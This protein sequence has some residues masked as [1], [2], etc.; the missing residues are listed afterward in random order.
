MTVTFCINAI[1]H[2]APLIRRLEFA[3]EM[4]DCADFHFSLRILGAWENSTSSALYLSSRDAHLPPVEPE[5]LFLQV[6]SPSKQVLLQG[7]QRNGASSVSSRSVGQ[8]GDGPILS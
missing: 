6:M 2:M 5:H 8:P 1:R 4:T 3:M 7:L